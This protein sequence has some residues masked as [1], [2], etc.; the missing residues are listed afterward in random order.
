LDHRKL[1]ID[2]EPLQVLPSLA[3]SIG[4][5]DALFLQQLH[6]W[7][8]KSKHEHDGRV[9]IY[10]TFEEWKEQFPFWS[11]DTMQRIAKRLVDKELIYVHQF[12][13]TDWDR[14]NW[15]AINY[16][17]LEEYSA[18]IE[19]RNLRSSRTAKRGLLESRNLRSSSNKDQ[20]NNQETTQ[21]TPA[22]RVSH[23]GSVPAHAE[24]MAYMESSYGKTINFKR[25]AHAIKALLAAGYSVADIEGCHGYLA[26]ESWRGGKFV[27]LCEVGNQIKPWIAGRMNGNGA[28]YQRPVN[29]SDRRNEA[30][31]KNLAYI[32]E[33][34]GEGCGDTDESLGGDFIDVGGRR[35]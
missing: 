8:R 31:R 25:E 20:E 19:S 9:W 35:I 1:L 34:R 24:L 21:E 26:L 2:E 15:Y 7:L 4:L 23:S 16:D 27:S 3:K 6:Y 12:T 17:K 10:N 33:L 29:A 13:K 28:N 18:A 11:L 32:K 14:K 22:V 30:L 5:N